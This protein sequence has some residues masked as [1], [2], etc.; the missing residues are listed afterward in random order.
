MLKGIT[1][2]FFPV[3]LSVLLLGC[4]KDDDG[5]VI[6][7]RTYWPSSEMYVRFVFTDGTNVLDAIGVEPQIFT[8]SYYNYPTDDPAELKIEIMNV[9]S[10]IRTTP[11]YKYVRSEPGN[12]YWELAHSE[13]EEMLLFINWGNPDGNKKPVE[14]YDDATIIKLKSKKIFGNNEE[15]II[16]WYFHIYEGK[17]YFGVYK[18]DVDGEN[19]PLDE[20]VYMLSQKELT[21]GEDIQEYELPRWQL[22][23]MGFVN[24]NIGTLDSAVP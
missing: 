8:S 13:T 20:D 19:H 12:I 16:K 3:L 23:I 11:N 24:M 6:L 10:G 7:N 22:R 9:R 1:P 17:R 21:A 4:S 5:D 15:H 18:C 14:S 2:Y